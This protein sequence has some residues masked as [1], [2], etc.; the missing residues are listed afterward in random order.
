MFLYRKLSNTLKKLIEQRPLVY[1]NGARQVGKSTLVQNLNLS[2][3]IN[4]ITLDSPFVLEAVKNDATN[5]LQNLPKD[6]INI[7]DEVQIAKELFPI[8]KIEID[9]ARLKKQNVNQLYVLT[10]SANLMALPTLASY[11]AGRMAILTLYPLSASE[12]KKTNVN[13]IEKLYSQNLEYC[14]LINKDNLLNIIKNS[15]YPEIALN[16]KIDR[17]KWLDDYLSTILQ[18]DIRNM[19]DIKNPEKIITLLSFLATRVGGLLNNSSIM[20]EIG[21]DN[22]TYDK[23]KALAMNT[24]LT[25]EVKAWTPVTKINKKFTKSSKLY[26]TDINMLC[27]ILRDSLESVYEN[28]KEIF[29]SIFENFIATEI[30][31]NI[32]INMDLSYFKTTDNKEVDFVLEN[33]RG[34]ILAIEVKTAKTV[35]DKD[36]NALQELQKITK[37]KF[38]KGIVFYTG[39]EIVPMK[40]DIWAVPV[41]YIWQE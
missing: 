21:L 17:I 30:I 29:G 22:K 15:T 16:Q 31:K 26:F 3:K 34:E 11:L 33:N 38:K 40:K 9:N 18:R 14:K 27:Y 19:A 13:F 41:N 12:Y 20:K 35:T 36:T 7:I 1:L 8:L 2:K 32:D 5:F 10:G 6:K 28:N 25:F 37:S 4:Y 23:Y 24:F 39:K